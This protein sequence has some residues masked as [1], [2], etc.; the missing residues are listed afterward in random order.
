MVRRC[1]DGCRRMTCWRSDDPPRNRGAQRREPLLDRSR[2][3]GGS[4]SDLDQF[5]ADRR[6]NGLAMF[7]QACQIPFDCIL[8]VRQRFSAR[9]SLGDASGQRRTFRHKD[10][11]LIDF[12]GHAVKHIGI[13]P[14]CCGDVNRG[15]EDR[16]RAQFTYSPEPDKSV[17]RSEASLFAFHDI[18]RTW[19]GDRGMK[20]WFL[21]TTSS[22]SS[23]SF[24][25][26]DGVVVDHSHG[27]HECI[28][29]R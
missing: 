3:A 17:R 23:L 10:A 8:D 24:E 15:A 29:N 9:L 2:P 4:W 22:S 11:V 13:V 20:A 16:R 21:S 28:A 1:L 14:V 18:C 25:A 12:D 6:R 19:C 5:L 27:L 7:L 26:I